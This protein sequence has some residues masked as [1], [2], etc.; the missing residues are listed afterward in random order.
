M[1]DRLR[2]IEAAMLNLGLNPKTGLPE[3][4]HPCEG[5][6]SQARATDHH[7]V[8]NVNEDGNSNY[9]GELFIIVSPNLR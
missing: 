7:S 8:L 5:I 4:N 9:V 6:T 1:E 2:R 3:P